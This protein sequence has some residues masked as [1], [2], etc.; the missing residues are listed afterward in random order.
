MKSLR[1]AVNRVAKAGI[2]VEFHD[3]PTLPAAGAGGTARD[4]RGLAAT[5]EAERGYSMTL[6]RLFDPADTGV[7]VSVARF[8]DGRPAGF[9]QWTPAAPCRGTPWT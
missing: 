3:G 9:V 4:R 2:T 6:S 5:G 1:G 7:L 8:A